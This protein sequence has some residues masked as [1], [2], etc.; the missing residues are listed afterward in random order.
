MPYWRE[1]LFSVLPTQHDTTQHGGFSPARCHEH[2]NTWPSWQLA[3]LSAEGVSRRFSRTLFVLCG[4]S[5]RGKSPGG[6]APFPQPQGR[7]IPAIYPKYPLHGALPA[8]E[9]LNSWGRSHCLVQEKEEG[10]HPQQP[11]TLGK[12]QK[13]TCAVLSS[14]CNKGW[15]PWLPPASVYSESAFC[16]HTHTRKRTQMASS[17]QVLPM[18]CTERKLRLYVLK[19]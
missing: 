14:V 3:Y 15:P 19:R 7:Q 17:S 9:P 12:T 6:S 18:H 2:H 8:S 4:C 1:K 16:L 13:M 11:C 10:I 5:S